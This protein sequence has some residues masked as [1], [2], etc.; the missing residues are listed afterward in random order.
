M[1]G[2][3]Y[4]DGRLK[5]NS[6]IMSVNGQDMSEAVQAEAVKALKVSGVAAQSLLWLYHLHT[7]MEIYYY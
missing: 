4:K 7:Y 6:R 5:A 3:A 2:V 1:D